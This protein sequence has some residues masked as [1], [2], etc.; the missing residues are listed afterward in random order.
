MQNTDQGGEFQ[1]SPHLRTATDEN[2]AGVARGLDG[3]SSLIRTLLP[4]PGDLQ[5]F[6]GR[7]S[8]RCVMPRM[9]RKVAYVSII[10]FVDEPGMVGSPERA[11]QHYGRAL[12]V[13]IERTALRND[14]L[15]N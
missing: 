14:R 4:D 1:Y 3:D 2:Y 10:R 8:L 7:H 13:H 11:C 15:L 12:P 5:I 9:G 6:K